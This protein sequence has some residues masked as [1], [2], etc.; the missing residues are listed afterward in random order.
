MDERDASTWICMQLPELRSV[1]NAGGWVARLD[2]IVRDARVSGSALDACRRLGYP[3]GYSP[4]RGQTDRF[5]S[6][7]DLNIDPVLV[8]GAYRCPKDVCDRRA[9]ANSRGEEPRCWLYEAT[10]DFYPSG[11]GSP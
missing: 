7:A 2:R 4:L 10:M 3:S 6:L 1:A 9:G 11:E 8:R 5:V